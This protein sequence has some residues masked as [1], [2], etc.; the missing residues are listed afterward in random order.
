MTACTAGNSTEM[1]LICLYVGLPKHVLHELSLLKYRV[2]R[3]FLHKM[4]PDAMQK[5]GNF[6]SEPCDKADDAK[7]SFRKGAI[8]KK[9]TFSNGFCKFQVAISGA[10]GVHTSIIGWPKRHMFHDFAFVPLSKSCFPPRAGSI[11]S[12]NRMIFC[13]KRC[14]KHGRHKE[15]SRSYTKLTKL[16]QRCIHSF[17][18]TGLWGRKM[19]GTAARSNILKRA[20]SE[21]TAIGT[22]K[23]RKEQ[24]K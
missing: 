6:T 14:S 21:K 13:K 16:L 22:G 1:V 3:A 11:F 12:E 17:L 23:E 2:R 20:W 10:K 9:Y 4:R 18:L 15:N 5:S 24:I 7:C 8:N 19:H